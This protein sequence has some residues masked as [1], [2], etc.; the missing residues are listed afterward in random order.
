MTLRQALAAIRD[1]GRDNYGNIGGMYAVMSD[2]TDLSVD[3]QRATG[4]G[5]LMSSQVITRTIGERVSTLAW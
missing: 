2:G 3:C 5:E 1:A 4:G